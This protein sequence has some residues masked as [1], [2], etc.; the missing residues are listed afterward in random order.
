MK[1]AAIYETGSPEVIRC[2]D[3]PIPEPRP[4]ELLIRVGAVAVNPIDT[5]IRSGVVAMPIP[6]PYVVGCDFAGTVE[7][8]GDEVRG[9]TVGER[10]WGSNQGLFGRQGT[11]A[12]YIAVDAKWCYATPTD[13][14]DTE[15]AAGALVGITAHLGLFLH[16]GL[17]GGE[18]VF[19]NGGTGGVGSTV[20]QLAKSVGAKVVTTAGTTAKREH[21]RRL[22][23]DLVL[24]YNSPAI[25][26]DLRRFVE[27]E[28]DGKGFHVWFET[29]RQPNLDRTVG[30]MRQRGR[31]VLMAGRD[32]RPEFPLG[33]FYTNDLRIF[34]F[35]MFNAS[36]EEQK[37]AGRHLGQLYEAGN[38]KPQVGK[39]FPLA[40]AAAAH[41]LQEENTLHGAGTLEG[42]IVLVP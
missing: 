10:V 23:A 13:M 34:G 33:K 39:T 27:A 36:S 8:V 22:G 30:L 15:A 3:M 26:D 29:Q 14:S 16:A 41:R 2:T 40:E 6:F 17:K 24:D 1:A 9:F 31:I 5:Y 11:F 12:E 18:L 38:W 7:R 25:E 28:G 20:V 32:A 37:E 35:A 19:V 21:A 4:N 42:K